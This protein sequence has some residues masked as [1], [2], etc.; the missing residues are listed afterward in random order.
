MNKK[1]LIV[2][3][4][5]NKTYSNKKRTEEVLKGL[6]LSICAGDMVAI[7]GESGCGKSSLLNIVG[8]LDEQYN[9][10]YS[11][12]GKNVK[13]YSEK[14]KASMRNRMFGFVMQDFALIDELSVLEN[15]EIPLVYSKNK[16]Y[17][18]KDN[19]YNYIEKALELLG[20]KDKLNSKCSELSGGQ[21]Q[22]VAIA[23]AIIN[24]AKIVLADEPT[25][26]LDESSAE[27]I[28]KLLKRINELLNITVIMVTHD[29]KV[30]EQ[31]NI[32]YKMI[33]GKLEVV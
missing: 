6:E 23:R 27:S 2:L 9:G 14:D 26:A 22:R 33:D 17:K 16:K 10:E 7:M 1:E 28:V 13:N 4:N 30:A 25:G 8:L 11:L 32:V 15:I 31:C 21:R 19:R 20:I 5:I 24:D 12:D 3:K 29:K 18:S